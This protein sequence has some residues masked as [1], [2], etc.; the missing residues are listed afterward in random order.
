MQETLLPQPPRPH[1]QSPHLR[2][3]QREEVP[4]S[5]SDGGGWR[6]DGLHCILCRSLR[7]SIQSPGHQVRNNQL[8]GQQEDRIQPVD[9]LH[10]QSLGLC[11]QRG[12][13]VHEADIQLRCQRRRV[14]SHGHQEWQGQS[15]SSRAHR[16]CNHHGWGQWEHLASWASPSHHRYC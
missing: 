6:R 9:P 1:L 15:D 4:G 16:T 8:P 3:Q 7:D 13:T 12:C 10:I 2:F 11:I 14:L 5:W